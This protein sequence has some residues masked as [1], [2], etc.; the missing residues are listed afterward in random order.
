MYPGL[1][2]SMSRMHFDTKGPRLI[3]HYDDHQQSQ[4]KGN[5]LKEIPIRETRLSNLAQTRA[6]YVQ[7]LNRQLLS[8]IERFRSSEIELRKTLTVDDEQED[9]RKPL[10]SPPSIELRISIFEAELRD[11]SSSTGRCPVF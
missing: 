1:E 5:Q 3:G 8:R 10:S 9:D 2:L 4:Y 7:L 11:S 6:S